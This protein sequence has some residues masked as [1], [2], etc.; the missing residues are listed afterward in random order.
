M[1][2]L[3]FFL[4]LKLIIIAIIILSEIMKVKN[5]FDCSILLFSMTNFNQIEL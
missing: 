3:F 4:I 2:F 1:L 5:R